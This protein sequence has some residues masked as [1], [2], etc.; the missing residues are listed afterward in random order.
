MSKKGLIASQKRTPTSVRLSPETRKK[1]AQLQAHLL[2]CTAAYAIAWAVDQAASK[3][4][5]KPA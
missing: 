5:S 1:I 2:H 4:A 3:L